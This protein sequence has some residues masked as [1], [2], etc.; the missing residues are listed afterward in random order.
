MSFQRSQINYSRMVHTFI[1]FLAM[2][3]AVLLPGWF[4][5][6]RAQV[7]FDGVDDDN[8][9]DFTWTEPSNAGSTV[10]FYNVYLA[11]D[12]GEFQHCDTTSANAYSVLGDSG[13]TYQIKVAGVNSSGEEGLHSPESNQILC[14][15]TEP[16]QVPPKIITQLTA[17]ESGGGVLLTWPT[18]SE[19]SLGGPEQI[20]HYI[21]Y[22]SGDPFFIPQSSDSI[23]GVQT[24]A[25]LD[26]QGSIGDPDRNGYYVISAVDLAGNQSRLSNRVGE[27]D[28]A[29]IPQRAGYHLLAPVLDNGQMANARNLGQAIPNCTAVK[30]WDPE[31]QC[32]L[33]LA[34]KIEDSWYGEA[35]IQMGH[36]YYIFVEAGPESTWTM[37]GGIPEE[38]VFTL[39]APGGN[40]YNT[41]TLPLSSN[42]TLA[43]EL[44]QSIPNCTA[45]KRWDPLHQGYES[46]AFKVGATWY[47][48]TPIQKGM[49]YYVN[50]T[51][52]G[53][54]PAMKTAVF[55]ETCLRK[56]IR[57]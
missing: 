52:P 31:N 20:S 51:A 1:I 36:P 33:S 24:S 19:D 3:L 25:F 50:V 38:P 23:A 34:F 47:G 17:Q 55:D 21:V 2:G 30:Q 48:D 28:F 8:C 14:Q 13:H 54:W 4:S 49:P 11:V 39:S 41:I 12:G 46:I 42:L 44:G 27:F 29:T 5:A 35:P 40:G 26:P 56:P 57:K 45:V 53:V 22:R 43:K 32:Y 16:D 15:A 37:V 18:V 9:L 7:K 10:S 6:A